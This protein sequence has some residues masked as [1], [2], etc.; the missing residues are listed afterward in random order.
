MKLL[1]IEHSIGGRITKRTPKLAISGLHGVST[2]EPD[3]DVEVGRLLD[4]ARGKEGAWLEPTIRFYNSP[5][6]QIAKATVQQY[7]FD[8]A[9]VEDIFESLADQW[10]VETE[11]LSMTPQILGHPSYFAIVALG[12]PAVPLV[13]ERLKRHPRPWF[14]ALAAMTREDPAT[15]AETVS[16]A[17]EAWLDWGRARGLVD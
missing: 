1:E 12:F 6:V 17:T 4:S 9:E 16:A 3:W 15:E 8:A 14:V 7:P 2:I 11:F 5:A 10:E 13:L